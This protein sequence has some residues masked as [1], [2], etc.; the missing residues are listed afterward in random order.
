MVISSH[1]KPEKPVCCVEREL[2]AAPESSDST[3]DGIVVVDTGYGYDDGVDDDIDMIDLGDSNIDNDWLKADDDD[4]IA[5]DLTDKELKTSF[6]NTSLF[7]ICIDK[8]DDD[9]GDKDDIDD[10]PDDPSEPD[11]EPVTPSSVNKWLLMA[12]EA[13]N[14]DVVA[15]DLTDEALNSSFINTSLFNICIDDEDDDDAVDKD[16][17]D[18]KPDDPPEPDVEPVIPSA[19]NKWLLCID[20]LESSKDL[21]WDHLTFKLMNTMPLI[22][23]STSAV[24]NIYSSSFQ[25]QDR[26]SKSDSS[27]EPISKSDSQDD[28]SSYDNL[29]DLPND[30][31]RLV[32]EW[33]FNPDYQPLAWDDFSDDGSFKLVDDNISQAQ[34]DKR[35]E[36]NEE[37]EP[38]IPDWLYDPYHNI[39]KDSAFKENVELIIP[40]WFYDPNHSTFDETFDESDYNDYSDWDSEYTDDSDE[41][42]SAVAIPN[43]LFSQRKNKSQHQDDDSFLFSQLFV[44]VPTFII[45][46]F[47]TTA[48]G[49]S[50][51]HGKCVVFV[52]FCL[53]IAKIA[54]PAFLG[55]YKLKSSYYFA[56]I[57][58]LF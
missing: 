18:D 41:D 21:T 43:W 27:F 31:V 49:F 54:L 14:D 20:T 5:K 37:N 29:D 50:I 32:P 34:C 47:L 16:D 57:F 1:H 3:I 10:Q 55:R 15:K 52:L 30:D 23:A 38:L 19:V 40:A 33:F 11:V 6:I 56:F 17:I 2:T 46:L 28:T 9:A 45:L 36:E 12:P 58:E 24:D 42:D 39:Y 22:M 35:C 53:Y 13:D 8:D 26:D 48:L 4:V 51:G 7:N 25:K 44:D